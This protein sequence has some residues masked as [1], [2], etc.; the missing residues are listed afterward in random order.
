L[1]GRET[2]YIVYTI[3]ALAVCLGIAARR[4]DRTWLAGAAFAVVLGNE[5]AI[6]AYHLVETPVGQ[7]SKANAALLATVPTGKSVFIGNGGE[8]GY[9]ALHGRNPLLMFITGI[10]LQPG[11]R[12]A[13]L[14]DSRDYLVQGPHPE[15]ADRD[16]SRYIEPVAVI[17]P[18]SD[19]YILVYRL[20]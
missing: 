13:D 9:F 6:T 20:N 10:P 8:F 18:G 4:V 19:Y 11:V 16:F 14:V 7:E 17:K 2:I 3:P 15:V 1:L 12:E 5:G